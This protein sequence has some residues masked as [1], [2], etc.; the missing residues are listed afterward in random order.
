MV[1]LSP[2]YEPVII[3]GL[4]VHKDNPF[5][6][7][8]IVDVGQDKLSGEPLKKEGEKL[9]K[10]FLASLAIPDKDV[11]VNLS[12]YE[13]N[14]M[15]PTSLGQ[16]DMGRDLLEQ[17][18]I[19]KQ[20]T[21]SLIYP[22]KQLGKIFWD[23]VYSK[24]QQMYGTTQVPVNTFNKVWI[25]ADRAEVFEH[26]QTA[27]VVDSHLKVMLEE[28]YL[29]LQKHSTALPLATRND[30]H[31]I[32]ANI[33]KQIILPELEKEVNKGRNFANLRQ[34]FNSIIL[35]SW[36]KKNLK[37][38]LL[39]QVYAD[40]SRVKGINLNDPTVKGQIY[41][42]YLKAY[43]K[44]VFNYIKEDINAANG[45]TIPRKYFSGGIIEAVAAE[46]LI[47][48][49]P[50]SLARVSPIDRAM[51]DITVQA[52]TGPQNALPPK[53]QQLP[54]KENAA[55]VNN[56]RKIQGASS[57]RGWILGH[58]AELTGV[59]IKLKVRQHYGDY[60]RS[61]KKLIDELADAK[62]KR[63]S[64]LNAELR[65]S[66]DRWDLIPVMGAKGKINEVILTVEE[67]MSSLSRAVNKT[68]EVPYKEFWDD[69]MAPYKDKEKAFRLDAAKNAILAND[70]SRWSKNR[71][72]VKVDL[73]FNRKFRHL[74]MK[75]NLFDSGF[76]NDLHN[77]T[78]LKDQDVSQYFIDFL[79]NHND[80]LTMTD[81]LIQ[82][83]QEA[84][85]DLKLAIGQVINNWKQGMIMAHKK[86]NTGSRASMAPPNWA[87][88]ASAGE[89]PQFKLATDN[90]PLER[91]GTDISQYTI[92]LNLRAKIKLKISV[93]DQGPE[94][95]E[96]RFSINS[97]EKK[98]GII[99]ARYIMPFSQESSSV[100]INFVKVV[101][102]KLVEN[103]PVNDIL[104][105]SMG[106]AKDPAISNILNSIN[107]IV[108]E[109]IIP[110]VEEF[111]PNVPFLVKWQE[112]MRSSSLQAQENV[113]SIADVKMQDETL[114]SA[115]G[116]IHEV[117]LHSTSPFNGVLPF[118]DDRFSALERRVA[119]LFFFVVNNIYSNQLSEEESDVPIKV[120]F[121]RL[122][123]NSDTKLE[124]LRMK[125]LGIL[126][127]LQHY[128][129]IGV[130]V[131]DDQANPILSPAS[132]AMTAK[133]T[134]QPKKVPVFLELVTLR[135]KIP[136]NLSPDIG[137]FPQGRPKKPLSIRAGI[138]DQAEL[139]QIPGGIDL[140]T[141]NGMRWK[142][143][144]DGNGVEMTVDP[145]VI[146]RIRHIGVDW[147]VPV[148][149]KMTP[150]TSI[151]PLVGLQAPAVK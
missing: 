109:Q 21:A 150:V 8:F 60:P 76:N 97:V 143:S 118:S 108:F 32:G 119:Q 55:T 79:V 56:P 90:L 117:L 72:I 29:A 27:F 89:F 18:Y 78:K 65:E 44:G 73:E 68:V 102:Q 114:K 81:Y 66:E 9:V 43:K 16:T 103:P 113:D 151:W 110:V 35:S 83:G 84:S 1:N 28:D 67:T 87:M 126:Y 69:V 63:S 132:R 20:I 54:Q 33:V 48:H 57:M 30:S 22:E 80:D 95:M 138:K 141:S 25:M 116:K 136:I 85:E 115:L 59:P 140:N 71:D 148:I 19:L 111:G 139:T 149:L 99:L 47:S 96:M 2:A 24:A 133:K 146:E 104:N 42:Q 134:D 36:Y 11:W 3:K 121:K 145:V 37:D 101:A 88:L 23:K 15:I 17:D 105:L 135:K 6:F 58:K 128:L 91:Q 4:T 51:V 34:I 70:P 93:V 31:S 52:F 92:P 5:L 10:Y 125:C 14:R 112:M 62:Y 38:A 53:D 74:L 77:T 131:F 75:G 123:L 147:L 49:D 86:V 94:G 40:K 122:R 45:E 12:P 50:A 142:V 26:D 13:K 98:S 144:K 61:L 7:D 100:A 137:P 82:I 129:E 127:N 107:G 130:V 120:K 106:R 64:D 46:P 39:N 41:E 124:E